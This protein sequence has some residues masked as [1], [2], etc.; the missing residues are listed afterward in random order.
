[1]RLLAVK[2]NSCLFAKLPTNVLLLIAVELEFTSVF[3]LDN[4][5]QQALIA[6]ME[7]SKSSVRPLDSVSWKTNVVMREK[8]SAQT[9]EFV[10]KKELAVKVMRS[11]AQSLDFAPSSVT[12]AQKL[13]ELAVAAM[14]MMTNLSVSQS[15]WTPPHNQ[16][17]TVKL[18]N[19]VY[20]PSMTAA[21]V[22]E[23]NTSETPNKPIWITC[24]AQEEA[25]TSP[26]TTI[27]TLKTLQLDAAHTLETLTT[28]LV[29]WYLKAP[30]SM[31]PSMKKLPCVLRWMSHLSHAH[32]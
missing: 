16:T 8:N 28:L 31:S 32:V 15:L 18:A 12:V 13:R 6:V 20:L 4:V 10:S 11:S 24:V 26:L 29:V 25:L 17:Y 23:M 1:M 19:N 3:Q 22:K 2:M 30:T 9:S 7:N 14:T 5:N 21:P 27:S